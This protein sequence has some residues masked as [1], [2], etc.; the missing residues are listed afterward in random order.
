MSNA[1]LNRP[2][3]HLPEN[4]KNDET[5]EKELIRNYFN[6]KKNGV[7]VEVGANDPTSP[8]SQTF[9]LEQLLGW[10]GLL[11]EPIPYLAQLARNERLGVVVCECACTS[12]EKLEF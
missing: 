10:T 9:H 11:V 3:H 6:N 4:I 8:E 12:P 2:A 7:F 1:Y 5:V